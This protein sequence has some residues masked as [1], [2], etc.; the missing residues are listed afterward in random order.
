M[1]FWA[2]EENVQWITDFLNSNAGKKYKDAGIGFYD[3][4]L[5]ADY[6][7]ESEIPYLMQMFTEMIESDEFR[8][9]GKDAD[10]DVSTGTLF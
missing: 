1:G 6:A 10:Y 3:G 2:G 4:K 9:K 7:D 5:M 8:E